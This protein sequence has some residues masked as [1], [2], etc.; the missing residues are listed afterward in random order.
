VPRDNRETRIAHAAGEE[1]SY[2]IVKSLPDTDIRI[3][4]EKAP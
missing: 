4:D 1:V 2:E 3:E